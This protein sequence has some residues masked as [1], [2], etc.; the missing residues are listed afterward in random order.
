MIAKSK[1]KWSPP[2]S[3]ELVNMMLKQMPIGSGAMGSL[4]SNLPGGRGGG[5]LGSFA[6]VPFLTTEL[7]S[8]KNIGR[9][10]GDE[11]M[12]PELI[13]CPDGSGECEQYAG[14]IQNHSVKTIY[15]KQNQLINLELD[16][17][18]MTFEYNVP[19]EDI[20]PGWDVTYTD[21]RRP[22]SIPNS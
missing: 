20:P 2:L 5:V 1:G 14:T 9:L 4:L 13:T 10:L 12:K 11:Q 7:F 15:D 18:K 8:R 3:G 16:R 17:E 6:E 19:T 22:S 21:D